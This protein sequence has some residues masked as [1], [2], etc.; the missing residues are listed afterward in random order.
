MLLDIS[1]ETIEFLIPLKILVALYTY[2]NLD[3]F[4]SVFP[5]FCLNVTT[6]QALALEYLI[7]LYPFGLT[8][9]SYF[10]II[11]YDR[12]VTFIVTLWKPFR[13]VLVKFRTSWDIHTS[14]LDSFV[15]FFFLSHIKIVS[16]TS[17]LLLPT[18]IYQLGSNKTSYG[19]YYSPS[20][21]YFGKYH[22]PYAI[23]AIFI[24]TLF[25]I[26]PTVILVL[27][28]CCFFQK[29]LS[30]FPSTGTFSMPLLTPFKA[31]TRMGQNLKHLIVACFH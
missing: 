17:D 18:E 2:W 28:P 16:V 1:I 10:L 27:H 19:L 20:V 13:K 14:V 22:L 8:F 29:F 31:L 24:V 12:R 21:A 15:T 6:L 30:L 5:D 7:A 11:L 4:H 23:P 9:I 25:V 3:L 26:V